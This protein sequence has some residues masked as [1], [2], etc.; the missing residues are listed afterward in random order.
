[1]LPLNLMGKARKTVSSAGQSNPSPRK[2]AVATRTVP[3][4][5]GSSESIDD[6]SSC[7]LAHASLEHMGS[8]PA[9]GEILHD[10]VQMLGPTGEHEA[11][12][13]LIDRSRNVVADQPRPAGVGHNASKCLLNVQTRAFSVSS[14]M[15]D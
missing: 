4:S 9:I 3:T 15:D 13:S 5:P 10:R 14:L 11:V 7:L 1:M 12:S 6:R 8:D 2:L